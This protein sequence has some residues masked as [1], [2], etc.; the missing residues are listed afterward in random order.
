MNVQNP[1]TRPNDWPYDLD[2]F[3][4]DWLHSDIKDVPYFYT[5]PK[6]DKIVEQGGLR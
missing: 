3:H 4:K 1:A 2:D 5:Y 6:F